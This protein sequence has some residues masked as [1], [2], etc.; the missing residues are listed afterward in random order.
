MDIQD[1]DRDSGNEEGLLSVAF[2]PNYVNN[3]FFYVYYTNNNGDNVVS[4]YSRLN[5]NQGNPNSGLPILTIPHPNQLNHN[6]GQ[7]QFGPDDN[8]YIGTGDGGGAGDPGENGQDIN[9]LLGKI[10]RIDVGNGTGHI[11]NST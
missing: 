1:V 7:L 6:G 5:A 10:L 2:H 11:H 3:G 4:R 9:E 8:L